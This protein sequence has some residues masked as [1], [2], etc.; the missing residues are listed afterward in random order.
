MVT[1]GGAVHRALGSWCSPPFGLVPGSVDLLAGSDIFTGWTYVLGESILVM[2]PMK[3]Y[4]QLEGRLKLSQAP[5]ALQAVGV[6]IPSR[7]QY[8]NV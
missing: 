8:E 2:A 4:R 5:E 7:Q 6:L 1:L 3:T